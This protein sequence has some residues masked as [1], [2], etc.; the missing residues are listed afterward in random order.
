MRAQQSERTVF[1]ITLPSMTS[2]NCGSRVHEAQNSVFDLDHEVQTIIGNE[3]E[4]CTKEDFK[5]VVRQFLDSHAETRRRRTFFFRFDYDLAVKIL[6]NEGGTNIADT[7]H[8]SWVRNNF[9]LRELGTAQHPIPQLVKCRSGLPVCPYE[10]IYDVLCKL[11][12]GIH[13]HV[14][15]KAMWHTVRLLLDIVLPRYITHSSY[16]STGIKIL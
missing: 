8:R 16:Y 2:A 6:Q 4:F 15:Q 3:A 9:E 1:F 5:T 11:H 14:G 13:K 7:K 10:R 12:R